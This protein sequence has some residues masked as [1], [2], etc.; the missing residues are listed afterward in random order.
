RL[1]ERTR[2][3]HGEA[4]FGIAAERQVGVADLVSRV[5]PT[6]R[7]RDVSDHEIPGKA[8]HGIAPPALAHRGD[9]LASERSPFDPAAASGGTDRPE[10]RDPRLERGVE[11]RPFRPPGHLVGEVDELPPTE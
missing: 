10:H 11:A 5:L 8:P 4:A 6:L 1:A 3:L 9:G 2:S 7:Q